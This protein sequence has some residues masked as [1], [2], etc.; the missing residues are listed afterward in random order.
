MRRRT[1]A[2]SLGAVLAC[3]WASVA[4][5]VTLVDGGQDGTDDKVSDNAYV[6]HDGGMDP[7]IQ[8]CNNDATNPATAPA[9]AADFD[10]NDGGGEKQ[11]NEPATAVDPTDPLTLSLRGTSPATA[12]SVTASS[13]SDSRRTPV[14][15]G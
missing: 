2:V 6:R 5:A 12:T 3:G 7:A 14:R 15:R 13:A 10:P 11:Q 1:I 9:T 4:Q 8:E